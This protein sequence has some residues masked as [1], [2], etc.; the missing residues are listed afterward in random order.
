MTNDDDGY[1]VNPAHPIFFSPTEEQEKI[2]QQIMDYAGDH[3]NDGGWDVIYECHT[4]ATVAALVWS[5]G[6]AEDVTTFEQALE[7]I[8]P[9]VSVYDDREADAKN[10]EF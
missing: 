6:G 8:K 9:I 3:Y 10:S 7:Q 4:A 5:Y 1:T 2:G